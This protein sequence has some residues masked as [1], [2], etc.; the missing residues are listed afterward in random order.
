MFEEIPF[1]FDKAMADSARQKLTSAMAAIDTAAENR[2]LSDEENSEFE[3]LAA[4]VKRHDQLCESRSKF[5]IRKLPVQAD[6]LPVDSDDFRGPFLRSDQ[7][8]VDYSR[9]KGRIAEEDG[10]LDLQRYMRGIA[11]GDWHGSDR[12]MRASSA[13]YPHWSFDRNKGY[14]CPVHKA[15]LAGYGPSAIHRRTWVFIDNYVPWTAIRRVPPAGQSAL[16]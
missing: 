5:M 2:A 8:F 14:P 11:T 3:S 9:A 4:Q 10:E 6:K 7:S 1:V 16:F 13:H 12:E 15:A